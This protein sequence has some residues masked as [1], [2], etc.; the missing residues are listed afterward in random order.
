MFRAHALFQGIC[1]PMF[2]S[3]AET[4]WSVYNDSSESHHQNTTTQ[5]GDSSIHL[6]YVDSGISFFFQSVGQKNK[7][8]SISSIA[9]GNGQIV[10]ML[11]KASVVLDKYAEIL[12]I[13]DD[14]ASMLSHVKRRHII[15]YQNEHNHVPKICYQKKKQTEMVGQNNF[16]N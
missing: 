7:Q 13:W 2:Q 5:R 14:K 6:A 15:P 3:G 4:D 1:L 12:D 11:T 9:C 16:Q 8:L 10:A